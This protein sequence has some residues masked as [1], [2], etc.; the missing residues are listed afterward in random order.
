M[1]WKLGLPIV[2]NTF[3]AQRHLRLGKILDLPLQDQPSQVLVFSL[4]L[5]MALLESSGDDLDCYYDKLSKTSPV[6]CNK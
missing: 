3:R 1:I 5:I 2:S 6:T 4:P